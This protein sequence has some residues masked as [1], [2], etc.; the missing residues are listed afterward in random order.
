MN[1]GNFKISDP[2]RL[3]LDLWDKIKQKRKSN[4]YVALPNLSIY[5]TWKN[6]KKSY[7][8]NKF[9]SHTK[10]I[11]LKFWFEHGMKSLNFLMNHILYEIF[12]IVLNISS[13]NV[14]KRLVILQ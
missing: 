9:K 14:E 13:K 2:Q 11:N 1:S 5:Y 7:K 12:T 4:K 6:I 8:N 3:L 10:T